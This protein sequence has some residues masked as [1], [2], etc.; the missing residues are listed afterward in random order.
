[1][2]V[3]PSEHGFQIEMLSIEQFAE[4][5]G[6]KRTTIYEWFKSGYLRPGRHYLRIGR[7]VRFPWGPELV[8]KLYEDSQKPAQ[9]DVPPMKEPMI[10]PLLKT[11]ATGKRQ[12]QVN[13]DY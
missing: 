10:R 13:L 8:Q 3:E 2:P 5:M 7:T 12:L 1:M 9:P 4:R 11:P 6:V